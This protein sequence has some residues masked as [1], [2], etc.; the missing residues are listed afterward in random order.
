MAYGQ[1][2]EQQQLDQQHHALIGQVDAQLLK[3]V[4]LEALKAVDI[5]YANEEAA[6]EWQRTTTLTH[7]L[8]ETSSHHNF[9]RP[10]IVELHFDY[11]V[12]QV[13]T[14]LAKH[15]P[16]LLSLMRRRSSTQLVE[17]VVR[18]LRSAN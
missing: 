8:S 13:T 4:L 5:Q 11:S 9:P 12:D 2:S 6:W 7:S 3:A 18:A 1:Q 14:G 17:D 16:E 10:S 15:T